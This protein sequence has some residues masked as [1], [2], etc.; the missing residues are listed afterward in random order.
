MEIAKHLL[1]TFLIIALLAGVMVTLPFILPVQIAFPLIFVMLFGFIILSP[2]WHA[3]WAPVA[4][5]VAS[6]SWENDRGEKMESVVEN[7]QIQVGMGNPASVLRVSIYNRT[8]RRRLRRVLIGDNASFVGRQ[9][10]GFWF[11]IYDRFHARRDGLV[12]VN[13][14]TGDFAWHLPRKK[15]EWT[16]E[17]SRGGSMV[18]ENPETE[19]SFE[20]NLA[21]PPNDGQSE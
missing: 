21:S 16:G 8:S 6:C 20:I 15:A 4:K 17:R 7:A 3:H 18:M 12:C 13:E 10:L 11:F 5:R 2:R 1:R 14:K 19:E 9:G